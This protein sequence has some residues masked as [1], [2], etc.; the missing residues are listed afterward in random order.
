MQNLPVI[1]TKE[2]ASRLGVTESRVVQLIRAGKLRGTKYGRDWLIEIK[3]LDEYIAWL[4]HWK[5][6][7]D[8]G[9]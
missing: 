7:K 1:I 8:G 4:N 9:R 6:K 2:A 5:D 3:S